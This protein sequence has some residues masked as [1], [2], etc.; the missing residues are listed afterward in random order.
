M[1]IHLFRLGQHRHRRGRGVDP[2][3]RFGRRHALHAVHAGF[4]FQ[5]REHVAAGDGGDDF[6]I[7]ADP[8]LAGIHDFEFPVVQGRIPGIHPQQVGGEQRGLVAAGAGPDLQDGVALVG[9]VLGQQQELHLLLEFRNA[10]LENRKLLL[11]HRLHLGI[12]E[13]GVEIVALAFGRLER[14]DALDQRREVGIFLR[15]PGE[16]LGVL[17]A[18]RRHQGGEFVMPLGDAIEFIG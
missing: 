14:M 11:G 16:S 9:L 12:G 4:E 10:R 15:Q 5:P 6:P 13:H 1:D 2:A 18:L 17:R 3:L 7:A 8:G